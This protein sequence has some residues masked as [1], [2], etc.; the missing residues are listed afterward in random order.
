MAR[1][2]CLEVS[3]A[4]MGRL[5]A[6]SILGSV[7]FL[8]RIFKI[9]YFQ[10]QDNKSTI[11]KIL[12]TCTPLLEKKGIFISIC[13]RLHVSLGCFRKPQRK[14]GIRGNQSTAT[15]PVLKRPPDQFAVSQLLDGNV[16]VYARLSRSRG[17]ITRA[18]IG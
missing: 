2:P 8:G 6:S 10:K 16:C 1:F 5:H 18:L 3:S 12:L 15:V 9:L 4:G 14:R 17:W 13:S 11:V 7:L